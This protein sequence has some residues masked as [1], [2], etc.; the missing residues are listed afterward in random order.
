MLGK[1]RSG[2]TFEARSHE[3]AL[4]S[5][6]GYLSWVYWQVS[7]ISLRTVQ[8]SKGCPTA[9]ANVRNILLFKPGLQLSSAHSSLPSALS[10]FEVAHAVS[11]VA[12]DC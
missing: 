4:A 7:K 5:L 11:A 8:N 6:L 12:W 9:E 2:W 1:G 10:V 3:E